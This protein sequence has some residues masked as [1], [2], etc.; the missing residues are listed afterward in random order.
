DRLQ[1]GDAGTRR[2]LG[3]AIR[4]AVGGAQ[5]VHALTESG[6]P[7]S[8]GFF[9]ELLLRLG[10]RALP[11]VDDAGDL[12]TVVRAIFPNPHDYQWLSGVSEATWHRLLSLLD[13]TA[14]AVVGV[15]AELASAV[16]VLAHHVSSLGLAPEITD[17]LPELDDL[18]SP[19]LRLTDQVL[20]Y[21]ECFDAAP[22]DDAAPRL[23]AALE[24]LAACR[25]AV[26][27]LRANKHRFGT[28]LRLTTLSFRLLRQVERLEVLLHLTAAEQQTFERAVKQLVEEL[29]E[30]ENTRNRV[31]RHV[32]AS[33]DLLA[34]QVVEHA[35]KKGR[36]YITQT[37][38]EYWRFLLASMGGGL[39]V[40]VFA[41]FKTLLANAELSLGAEALL[42]S[43][44]YAACF[45]VISLT[46]A[47]LAT[48]QPAMT[49]NTLA[50]SMGAPEGRHELDQL[51]EMI[52]RVW[53]SQFVSFAGNLICAFPMAVLLSELFLTAGAA[54]LASP[55]K[56]TK[57]LAEVHPWLSG[58]LFYAAVAGVFLF[59]AGLVS[60]WVDNRNLY[61]SIPARVAHHPL[62]RRLLGPA[63]A[64]RAGK[65]VDKHG[66][67]LLGNVFL[68]FCLG[69]AGTLGVILG[70]PF[71]IRHIAFSS[72]NVGMALDGLA[73]EV[74][75]SV[76]VEAALGVVLIGFVNFLV[77]FAL[78]LSMALESRRITLREHKAVFGLVLRRLVRRPWHFF[79]PPRQASPTP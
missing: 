26:V 27:G 63:R 74:P 54:P 4:R 61:R 46:G 60:G 1:A 53:R 65:F 19:F 5:C 62:L 9:D 29:V 72:A 17:R 20:R 50:R 77:S 57:L 73:W 42:F 3:D 8:R 13:L 70:L 28:S 10:R 43:L 11:E 15:P 56:A 58:A 71:D 18:D 25:R 41:V 23:A 7:G 32:R 68:G 59:L 45:I 14:D 40:A 24:T 2:A 67:V 79:W 55:D 36:K 48:K 37:A 33:A 52:V 66:G 21:T 64:A 44:N 78:T 38:R 76:L 75:G 47:A 12:R 69:C 51:A 16:R 30:A 22:G 6:I 49:A 35:A 39:I 31:G 34:F